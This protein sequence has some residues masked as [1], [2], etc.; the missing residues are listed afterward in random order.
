[1]RSS[2]V[3][4]QYIS[5]FVFG[6]L[7]FCLW[8]PKCP[9]L[10]PSLGFSPTPAWVFLVNT[11]SLRS[12]QH[13]VWQRCRRERRC[14]IVF[15]ICC[16]SSAIPPVGDAAAF[17]LLVMSSEFPFSPIR[18]WKFCV[19]KSSCFNKFYRHKAEVKIRNKQVLG[20]VTCSFFFEKF[21]IF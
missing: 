8:P 6:L 4:F 5:F 19:Y 18:N 17:W 9:G 2:A 3:W 7:V 1:M 11:A 10:L 12:A 13:P 21:K 14:K 16:T 15:S 20:Q